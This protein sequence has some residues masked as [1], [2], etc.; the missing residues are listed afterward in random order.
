MSD[1]QCGRPARE[2]NTPVL[3]HLDVINPARRVMAVVIDFSIGL[4]I[5]QRS[6]GRD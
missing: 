2:H 6:G 5:G 3:V 1:Y 4:G